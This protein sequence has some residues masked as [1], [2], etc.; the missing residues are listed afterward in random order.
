MKF[1][2][3]SH[4]RRALMLAILAF[5]LII[6]MAASGTSRHLSPNDRIQIFEKVWKDIDDVYY[7]PE[8]GGVNWQAVH[9]K[10]Q[11]LVG[12]AKDDSDF[13]SLL[14]HMTGELHDAHTRFS[15]PEQWRNHEKHEGVSVGFRPGYLEGKIVVLDVYPGSNAARAGI[16]TGMIVTAVDG[17]AIAE[18]LADSARKVLRSSTERVTQLRILSNAFAAPLETPFAARLQRAD[19]SEFDVKFARQI[20]SIP[21][22]VIAKK[23]PSG[24]GYIRFD[25]FQPA[26]V[27]GF[28]AT[29][30]DLR[31]TPGLILDL[32]WNRGGVG[33]TLEAMAG[34][35]FDGKTLFERRMTRKQVSASERDGRHVDETQFY[36]GK[37]GERLYPSPVVILVS[38]YYASATEVFAAG[39]QDSGRA[40]LVGS[41]SCGCVLGI[42]HNRVMKGGSVLEIS[43]IL[44]F[45]PKDR[46]LEGEGV[47]PDKIAVPTITSLQEKRDIVLEA[48]ERVL[49]E[50]ATKN[51]AASAP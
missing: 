2:L 45:S 25:E 15:S 47:V 12:A 51:P 13:Y 30:E 36:V 16:E 35:F 42:T 38:E 8:F 22:R 19:G 49:Q 41:Q 21:P 27:K 6:S 32:R 40:T 39:M 10:Y 3:P 9:Q 11:P 14:D 44:W 20:L 48:G 17:Q 24:F 29:L 43:E 37:R 28:K 23:L 26:L 31:T 4:A 18:R 1:V 33:A 7:D 50:M 46:K 5:G 34:F